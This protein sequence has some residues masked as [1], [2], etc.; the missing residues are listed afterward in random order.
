VV[1][2]LKPVDRAFL[3]ID[4]DESVCESLKFLIAQAKAS[5]KYDSIVFTKG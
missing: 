4:Q 3:S 1:Q 2:S 5:G